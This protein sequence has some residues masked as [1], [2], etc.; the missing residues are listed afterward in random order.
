MNKKFAL[1]LTTA[2]LISTLTACGNVA[3]Q[4]SSTPA[5]SASQEV[6]SNT[7]EAKATEPTV[8]EDDLNAGYVAV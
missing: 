5:G 3:P 4:N 8:T 2:L 6:S 1:L 7:S